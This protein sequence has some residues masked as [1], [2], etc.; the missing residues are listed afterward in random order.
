MKLI[1]ENILSVHRYWFLFIP[2]FMFV[3]ISLIYNELY[4]AYGIMLLI[5]ILFFVK[6]DMAKI[7]AYGLGF[8]A[9]GMIAMGFRIATTPELPTIKKGIY[10][11]TGTIEKFE[12]GLTKNK[13][14][15]KD[16][17]EFDGK[18]QLNTK[19]RMEYGD[20]ITVKAFLFPP[21]KPVIYGAFDFSKYARYRG[22][23]AY[24][25]ELNIIKHEKFNQRDFAN[26][27]I[28]YIYKNSETRAGGLAG[29]LITGNRTGISN[30]DLSSLRKS[31]LAHLLAI[32]GLH[33]GMVI[34]AVYVFLRLLSVI[35]LGNYST[36]YP[37]KKISASIGLLV[38]FLYAGLA[39]FP[40]P[41]VR[42]FLMA[43]IVIIG[44]MLGRGVINIRSVCLV[45]VGIL[46]FIPES[47]FSVSFQLSFMAVF[48]LVGMFQV[49]RH[50]I[51][52]IRG[53]FL[54]VVI[55]SL[56]VQ[57]VTMPFIVYHFGLVSIY[58]V[59]ANVIAIPV[60]T[61]FVAP[62]LLLSVFEMML[63]GTA[64][65]LNISAYGLNFLLDLSKF[66]TEL[67]YSHFYFTKFSGWALVLFVL[68]GVFLIVGLIENNKLFKRL[69]YGAG[70]IT[71][72]IM[73][74]P[75][76]VPIAYVVGGK[77]IVKTGGVYT[78][79]KS[80]DRFT[81]KAIFRQ[82]GLSVKKAKLCDDNTCKINDIII[83]NDKN[84]KCGNSAKVIIALNSFVKSC[85]IPSID[86]VDLYTNRGG[87][88]INSDYVIVSND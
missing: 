76:N 46:L 15:L 78:S 2:L 31:G 26:K 30:D 41:T 35:V 85:K 33:I 21:S 6:N 73:A 37:I 63:T 4:Y 67:D 47:L 43:S 65:F 7:C 42:A 17:D 57:I 77:A 40:I 23:I 18:I 19:N 38:A 13:I 14:I 81:K 44:L 84:Y 56:V 52:G 49:Y 83:T 22:I 45:A 27:I 34:G 66:V 29:A 1:W 10:E 25:K 88:Q 86:R 72:I 69:G 53:F 48:A 87:F 80:I 68:G 20:V 50:K 9:L 32:S 71:I 58:S 28:N 74:L 16:I 54:G 64:L 36:K 51:K 11:I 59:L 8:M 82:T 39:D 60:M 62:T 75:N 24:G 61:F 70:V 55:S 12:K 5:P 3:G 79:A